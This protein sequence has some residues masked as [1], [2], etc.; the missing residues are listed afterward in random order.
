[1]ASGQSHFFRDA[2]TFWG[3]VCEVKTIVIDPGHGGW[4]PGHI[5]VDGIRE[6]QF[7][8]QAAGALGE[9]LS[10]N[11]NCKIIYTHQGPDTA[12]SPTGNVDEELR[13]RADRANGSRAD[14]LVSMHHDGNANPNVR[15][16]SLWIWTNKRAP[17]GGLAWLPA[18]GNHTD[19]RTIDIARALV[20]P[21]RN[22]LATYGIPWR[23]FGDPEG[24]ACADFGVLRNTSGA[25]LLIEVFHGSNVQDT[26]A[27][28]SQPFVPALA[29]VIGDALAAALVLEGKDPAVPAGAILVN[30][31]PLVCGARIVDGKTV[32]ELRPVYE[33][34][35]YTVGYD[36]VRKV[37]TATKP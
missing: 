5:A 23:S 37:M 16:G 21:L 31:Q 25:A 27:A 15:G 26:Q 7:N 28:R 17:D 34:E 14:L 20:D 29:E 8:W 3:E 33:S 36:P 30:G 12:L 9:Y 35:G 2:T 18:A 24:I 1:M 6:A 11:Y 13:R 32:G 19:P 10:A 4:D 22:F